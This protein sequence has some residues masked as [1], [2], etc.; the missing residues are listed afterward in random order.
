[1]NPHKNGFGTHIKMDLGNL[2]HVQRFFKI[3]F[4]FRFKVMFNNF[5]ASVGCSISDLEKNIGSE[6]SYGFNYFVQVR[7]FNI[8]FE[9][10]F[11][12][13]EINVLER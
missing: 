4:G 12:L 6:Q 10:Q 1:M 8:W 5:M 2:V 3:G 11:V 7:K 13:I 9:F